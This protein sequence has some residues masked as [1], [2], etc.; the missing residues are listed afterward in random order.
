MGLHWLTIIY[1]SVRGNVQFYVSACSYL[2]CLPGKKFIIHSLSIC[3][4][5][6]VSVEI[7][8]LDFVRHS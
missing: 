6:T 5:A 3:I 7:S 4:P 8:S 2:R 1:Q